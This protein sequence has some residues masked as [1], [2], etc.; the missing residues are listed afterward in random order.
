MAKYTSGRQRNLKVGISSYSENLTS[1]EVIGKVGI[2]TTN[3]PYSL[4]VLDNSA[5]TEGLLNAIADFGGDVNSYSQVNIRNASTGSN[6]S[7]DLV[8]TADNGNNEI[9]FLDL[10]INNTGFGTDTWTINGPTDGYLYASDGNLSL[11]VGKSTSYLSLF[12]GGTLAE[13]EKV[14]FTNTGVGIGTT[15]TE[16]FLNVSGD[17]LFE[18]TT[19]N[20]LLRVS[21][22]G[23]GPAL[24]VTHGDNPN[25]NSFVVNNNGQ[26]GVGVLTISPEYILEVDGGDVRF[27]SGSQG[28][29]II[30]HSNLVSKIRANG[31][32]QLALGAN[33]QDAI[34]INLDNYIGVGTSIPTSKL[35][36]QGDV[37][38]SGIITA[39]QFST[40]TSGININTDTISGPSIMYIDPAPVGV[41]TTSG[42]VRIK[43]DLYVDGTQFVINSSTIELADLRVG[44]ATTVGSNL[45]LDGGG[46]GIGSANIL[47][48]F[49][50][51]FVS[52][53]LKSSENIDLASGKVYKI[54]GTELLSSSQLTVANINS[55]GVGTIA[56]FNST[57][58]S[59]TSLD[60]Q[61]LR[62]AGISTFTNGPVLIGS[63]S[64][65]GT[66]N[67]SLQ[68]TGGAYISTYVGIG[69]TNPFS[70]LTIYDDNGDGAWISLVDPGQSSSAIENN[71]GTLYIRAEEG[72]GN[73]KIVFQTGTSNYKERPSV[74]GSD[75]VEI[76]SLG[77][78]LV[79][80]GTPTGVSNQRLQVTG[81]G[82][83]SGNTGIGLSIPTSKLQVQG[84]VLVSGVV[85]ATTFY[86]NLY[87]TGISTIGLL[88]TQNLNVSGIITG[89]SY[90]V[91]GTQVISNSRQLQNIASLDTI[92]TATIEA[93]ISNAPND[94]QT[95]NVAGVSTFVNGPVQIGSGTS[96]GTA[97]QRLQVTG[98]GYVSANFGVGVTNPTSKL[99][100]QGDVLVS[101]VVTANSFR[102]S[103]GYIQAADGTNSFYIYN[104][105]GNVAFQGTIGVNQI[106]SGQGYKAIEF[107][108]TTT[109][110]VLVANN[111]NVAGVATAS[112]FISTSTTLLAPTAGNYGGER[113]RLYDF[114]NNTKTNYAIGVEGSHVWF[115]VDSNLEAQGFKWYGDT[116]QVMRLSAA[117][118]L[119]V[120][121][122]IAASNLL[123]SGV[124]T[125]TGGFVGNLTGIAASATQLV[126]P[127]TFQ[128]TGDVVSSPIS[129][130]GTGNVSLA[131]TIQPNSVALG[132][133][134]TGDYVQTVSGTSNQ[135]TVTGGTG[136]GSTPT[137]SLPTN[138]VVPEDLTVTRDL[139]V[140]RNLN[141]TGNITI[142]GTTA[143]VNV[144]ELRITDPD[145]ILGF[146][147][148]AFGND[149]SNDN[150]ANHG[151]IGL[152]STEGNPLVELFIAGIE[153]APATYKKIM[154]FKEGTFAG[155]GT[156][157]WLINYAVGIG[158]T[159]FPT[160]TTLAAGNVQFTQNDL[161]VVR[162]INASGVG[163]I[164][165]LSGTTATYGTGNFTTGNIVTGVVTTLT[166]TNATLTNI[167]SSGISTLGI[168]SAT[169]L[170]TQNINNS[171]ITTTNS[172]NIGATQVIS[173]SRQLQNIASLD[174]TT[175]ATIEAAIQNAPNT[176]TDIQV[177]GISTLGVTSTTNLT[178][179][180]LNVSGLSTFSNTLRVIP[181]STGIAGLF[182]G[183]T[184]SDM[185]RITQLGTGNAFVVEDATNPDATPFVIMADGKV[186]VGTTGMIQY[187]SGASD[188]STFGILASTGNN[189]AFVLKGNNGSTTDGSGQT[190]A[191]LVGSTG[192]S[193]SGTNLVHYSHDTS[194]IGTRRNSIRFTDTQIRFENNVSGSVD[195]TINSSGS[196]ELL[197]GRTSSTG[198]SNQL[199]QVQ[200]GAYILDSVGIGITNPTS[201][202]HVVGDVYITGVTTSTDFDSLSDINLK[203]NINQ[204]ADPLEKV[205][206][207]RGVTFNWKEGNRNSAGVIAQ[208]IEKVLPELVHGEETKTVNYNGL[209]GLLIECVKKQQ[210]E[211]DELKRKVN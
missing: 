205:M 206:Q 24:I 129:F 100:V 163:T 30:S 6:A 78:L 174:S 161:A 103:S 39:N 52:D 7:A 143:F 191:V 51:N 61:R 137:L 135:I 106:N 4:S 192:G 184:S 110:N 132:S 43:G 188:T 37:L 92:T 72:A 10:G 159:Q 112:S 3:A 185:V 97:S 131:A 179:Q 90:Y 79:N 94:F 142:G 73:S 66:L 68:V 125:S 22:L 40:G 187:G 139:Q 31:T 89:G 175:T 160:G 176:F 120:A 44:I 81:G 194:G 173:S 26:V 172:L 150:T 140:N 87:G 91:D 48:T 157:A 182:S 5:P 136:E 169:D 29:V 18:G 88:N 162:N 35:T 50:Y 62:V 202:L 67:Q 124:T 138:L 93:A 130:D 21:Q 167:N 33:G 200:G 64:Q 171:G 165:T 151:G 197:V 114:N 108:P 177:T 180:Q 155:L 16:S 147:T 115:G 20:E 133:D 105:N 83:V 153:T 47:K 56:T 60:L 36:V 193:G 148:D 49:I 144:Q 57:N 54:N 156:D 170:T 101:G 59:I 209:I 183:T 17:V 34:R 122:I 25:T 41:G 118:N 102:P 45:L 58:A 181:T 38:V 107:T 11:G 146:R 14:R 145:I 178:A 75:R 46:I 203:T 42:I 207:I 128:I 55:S 154:W 76:D 71:N 63:G 149:A 70:N 69:Y 8:L 119:S 201:K 141:V 2:G 123:I 74:S 98:G 13:N 82:Y 1:V 23:S 80:M 121:G 15:T 195:V 111:L 198:T 116:T 166:S 168:T 19:D 104:T 196:G 117:G 32:V 164:P 113:L 210:E 134:T 95:L 158:S 190:L 12:S 77:N 109:P 189:S 86:G 96:T 85:T 152:A 53:S 28:D 27:V 186:G 199:L 65:T 84:D 211:I 204:I 9:N 126:T 127:R 99:Q 208:E